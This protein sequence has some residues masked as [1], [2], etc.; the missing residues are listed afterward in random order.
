VVGVVLAVLCGGGM[1]LSLAAG[2]PT[3]VGGTSASPTASKAPERAVVASG[4][5]ETKIIG[6]YG[7]LASVTV[8]NQ[9]KAPAVG[10]IW[11]RWMIT[12]SEPVV[13]SKDVT[14]TPGQRATMHVDDPIDAERWFRIERCDY[15]WTA[16]KTSG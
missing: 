4:T 13:K 15:G 6:E 12:G 16:E 7:L 3:P 1:V 9:T 10:R 11:A 2:G 14:L 8:E 5:C